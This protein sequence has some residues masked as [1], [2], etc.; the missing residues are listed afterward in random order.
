VLDS[1]F[2]KDPPPTYFYPPFDLFAKLA[3][4]KANLQNNFY[5]NEYEFQ[6]DLY[7]VFAPAHDG[8]YIMYPDLLSRAFDWGRQR[9]LVSI[10]S[11]GVEIPQIYLYGEFFFPAKQTNR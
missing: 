10:S 5:A 3:S 11:D 1:A 4:V 7:Q 9:A 6:A 8:H 2:L